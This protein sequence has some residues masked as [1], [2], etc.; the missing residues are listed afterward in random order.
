MSN[1]KN[2]A[3]TLL[4]EES[5]HWLNCCLR[6][7]RYCHYFSIC[8]GENN[9]LMGNWDA[10]FYSIE[11]AQEFKEAM[12]AE[13]PDRDFFRVEGVLSIDG[14]ME[15]TPNKFW[16]TWQNKHKNRIAELLEQLKGGDK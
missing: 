5:Q 7:S 15:D 1:S 11:E 8:M 16:E 9:H 2:N 6:D 10:P 3:Q 4:S 14:A 12:Q 13:H